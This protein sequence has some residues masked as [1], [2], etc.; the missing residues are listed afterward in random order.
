MEVRRS[1]EAKKPGPR[2]NNGKERR[3]DQRIRRRSGKREVFVQQSANRSGWGPFLEYL[4]CGDADVI[5]GQET[6]QRGETFKSVLNT[7]R[8]KKYGRKAVGTE[9]IDG[10]N[11][12]DSSDAMIA[13][14][15]TL[16]P[17]PLIRED[18]SS[19]NM[20]GKAHTIVRGRA[21]AT[22]IDG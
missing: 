17:W 4:L 2:K 10:L 8:G 16:D 22:I 5:F 13:M 11:G 15:H 19:F 14:S 21:T 6:M 18:D 7:I 9:G 20:K 3:N 1:G 12:G